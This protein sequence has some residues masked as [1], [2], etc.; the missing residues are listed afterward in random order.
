MA[1][2]LSADER[3]EHAV[4]YQRLREEIDTLYGRLGQV[5]SDRSEHDLVLKQLTSL[6]G[7]RRCWHQVGAVLT[8]R[9]VS[10]VAPVLKNTR[11]KLQSTV[12]RI[13]ATV[14]EREQ[15]LADIA[16]KIGA[17]EPVSAAASSPSPS[18]QGNGDSK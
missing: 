3:R 1:A 10:D 7:E 11:D 6:N 8:E 16:R 12:E 4:Q 15:K 13:R 2:E 17:P 5:D 18:A 9:T 14:A